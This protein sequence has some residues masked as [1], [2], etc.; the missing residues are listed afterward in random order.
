MLFEPVETWQP[1]SLRSPDALQINLLLLLLIFCLNS[2]SC[3][4]TPFF[5]FFVFCY[6]SQFSIDTNV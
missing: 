3:R 4:V 2:D 5:L 1:S 6:I